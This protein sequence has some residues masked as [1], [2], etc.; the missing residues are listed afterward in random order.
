M[1]DLIDRIRRR[2]ARAI[3]PAPTCVVAT[4]RADAAGVLRIRLDVKP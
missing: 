1:R 4:F 2:L 3:A